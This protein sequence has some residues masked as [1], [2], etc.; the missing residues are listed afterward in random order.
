[1]STPAF[2]PIGASRRE[3][4]TNLPKPEARPTEQMFA[5]YH[6]I[7]GHMELHTRS[8]CNDL[9]RLGTVGPDGEKLRWLTTPPNMKAIVPV[10]HVQIPKLV[11]VEATAAPVAHLPPSV[12]AQLAPAPAPAPVGPPP[13]VASSDE[14][15][16]PA[17]R[18]ATPRLDALR[19][20]LRSLGGQPDAKWG[21]DSLQREI[22][23]QRAA[24]STGARPAVPAHLQEATEDEA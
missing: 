13:V 8:N 3:G 7:D 11:P 6:P 24:V 21:I 2:N 16:G 1:M 12:Q 15:D 20:E 23:T 19:Q 18:A 22:A 10:Q 5:V 4:M 14:F 9:I 17:D